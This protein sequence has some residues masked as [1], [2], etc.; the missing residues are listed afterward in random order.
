VTMKKIVKK[1]FSSIQMLLHYFL[2]YKNRQT[3]VYNL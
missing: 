1:H 3:K 2:H